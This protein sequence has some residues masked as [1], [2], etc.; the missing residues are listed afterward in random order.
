MRHAGVSGRA[1]CQG[2]NLG[3]IQGKPM[4]S[5]KIVPFLS[6]SG[7]SDLVVLIGMVLFCY[8]TGACRG[9]SSC[10]GSSPATSFFNTEVL[11]KAVRI[12]CDRG[13]FILK[14]EDPKTKPNSWYML[15]WLYCGMWIA[16]KFW[17]V[18]KIDPP[19]KHV[20]LVEKPNPWGFEHHQERF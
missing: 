8:Q 6:L 3:S 15:I 10:C 4:V 20:S 1:A 14:D 19:K 11:H 17:G 12:R 16:T 9:M 2:T 5:P 13:D 7:P 18:F